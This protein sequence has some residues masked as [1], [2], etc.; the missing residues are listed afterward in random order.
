MCV[1][2][3]DDFTCVGV[4]TSLD[5]MGEQCEKHVEVILKG[6]LGLEKRDLREMRV[7]NRIVRVSED[8]LAYEPDPRHAELIV[9]KLQLQDVNP[10]TTPHADDDDQDG[11]KDLK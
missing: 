4:D 7:L 5:H 1:V 8:G 10:L 11:P 6:K 2:H 3:G 9:E